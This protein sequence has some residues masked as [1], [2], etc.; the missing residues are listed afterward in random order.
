MLCGSQA[1]VFSPTLCANDYVPD[2]YHLTG[3]VEAGLRKQRSG[4][5]SGLPCMPTSVGDEQGNIHSVL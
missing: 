4:Q 2:S 3:T 1:A 5:S